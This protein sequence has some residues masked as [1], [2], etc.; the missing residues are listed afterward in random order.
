MRK[1][2]YR[3]NEE[4][5]TIKGN[6]E[7]STIWQDLRSLPSVTQI[8]KLFIMKIS[9]TKSN[10]KGKRVEKKSTIRSWTKVP[11]LKRS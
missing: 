2:D 5:D 11:Y 6:V 9:K 8:K 10:L 7:D 1:S 4:E 3:K